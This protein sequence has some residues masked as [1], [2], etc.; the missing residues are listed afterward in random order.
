MVQVIPSEATISGT[1]NDYSERKY[2]QVLGS[3]GV[4]I[5]DKI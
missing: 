3:G 2:Q 4:R 1:C 5:T